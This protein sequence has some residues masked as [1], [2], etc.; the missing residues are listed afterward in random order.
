M[1]RSAPLRWALPITIA[2]AVLA[3]C[4][5]GGEQVSSLDAAAFQ[6]ATAQLA[7]MIE[8]GR[9][10]DADGFE[11]A[12]VEVQPVLREMDRLL[13]RLPDEITVRAEL[14][15]AITRIELELRGRRRPDA[16]AEIAEDARDAVGEVPEALG[17][18]QQD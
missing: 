4:G 6:E 1:R 10:G 11:A 7:T 16:L 13:A 3:G 5:R 17:V 15:D 14:V 8:R 18:A 12:F 2:A 9:A